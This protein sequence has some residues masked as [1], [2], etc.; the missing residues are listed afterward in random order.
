MIRGSHI[1]VTVLGAL[2]VA[3]NGGA[4][5]PRGPAGARRDPST[6]PLSPGNPSCPPPP[7]P[8]ARLPLLKKEK[9]NNNS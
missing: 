1:D 4:C 3:A 5:A 8:P 9:N 6:P 2:E 7:R